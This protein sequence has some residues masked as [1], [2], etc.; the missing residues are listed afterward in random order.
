PPIGHNIS[1]TGAGTPSTD[2]DADVTGQVQNIDLQ[3][4]DQTIDMGVFVVGTISGLVWCESGTNPNISYNAGDGDTLQSNVTVTLYDD[5]DCNDTLDGAEAATAVTQDTVAGLYSF[6]NL[7]TGGPNAGDNPPGC[8]IVQVD[9]ADPDLGVC[10]NPVTPSISTPDIDAPNPNSPD[11]NFG[12]DE[13]LTLGDTVWYDNN[14]DGIQDIGEPG[15]NGIT[16]TLYDNPNCNGASVQTTITAVGGMPAVDGW[17]EFNPLPAGDY[18]IAFTNL[19]GGWVFTPENQ[20]VDDTVDSDVN[21]ATGQIT[22]IDLQ[23]NNPNEDVGIYAAIGTI[24]GNMFCDYNPVNGTEDAGEEQADLTINLY[25]DTDCDGTGDTLYRSQETDINGDY[26]FSNVPVA[27]AP[28]PPNPQVCYVVAYDPQD[29]DLGDCTTP[30]LPEEGIIELT[31]DA[32]DAP[33]V[34]FGTTPP[35]PIMIPTNNIWGLLLLIGLMLMFVR[36]RYQVR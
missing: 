31:T 5:T 29:P 7:I 14:Q 21:P 9:T 23:S 13:T 26:I 36:R 20:G 1:P 6:S 18:C 17:Y 27:F 16:V 2:S 35:A 4:T 33:A 11:N 8:Y 32:P 34:T 19:P 15:I 25:R 24:P 3:A 10:S 28:A 12:H 30:I 22:N